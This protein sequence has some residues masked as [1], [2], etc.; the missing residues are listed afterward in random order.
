ML[1]REA[2]PYEAVYGNRWDLIQPRTE[3][4]PE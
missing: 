3:G 4:D 2:L 1:D